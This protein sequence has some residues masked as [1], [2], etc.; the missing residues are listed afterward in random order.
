[1]KRFRLLIPVVILMMVGAV[2]YHGRQGSLPKE[3]FYSGVVEV[4]Q[5]HLAFERAGTIARYLADEG[6]PIQVGQKL[7]GL[8]VL[9]LKARQQGTRAAI[10]QARAQLEKLKAGSRVQEIESTRSRLRKAEA[11]L[12]RLRNGATAEEL[13]QVKSQM[14]A[15]RQAYAKTEH[16][17]RKEEVESARA[18]LD[19]AQSQM[20]TAESDLK[21]YRALHQEG[22]AP[23]Q[24]LEQQA[25]KFEIARSGYRTAQENYQLLSS[26]FRFEDRKAAQENFQ[27]AQARYQEMARGT[28]P[29][30]IAAAE[31]EVSYWAQQ[32]SL[33]KEGSRKEDI[34]VARAM[35]E[36]KAAELQ[37][38]EV[39]LK[40]SELFSPA[41][42][43]VTARPFEPGEMVAPG[44]PVLTVAETTSPWVAI[45]IPE[46]ELTS[47]HLGDTCQV[48]VDSQK[49]QKRTGRVVWIAEKAEFTPRYIQTE[50]QRVDLVFRVKV[51]VENSDGSLK[52]GMPADVQFSGPGKKQ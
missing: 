7:V 47:I 27:A 6:E 38:L 49:A 45:F 23:T 14:E 34:E 3:D 40:K 33:S 20:R 11:E 44:A 30:L 24:L 13:R 50:R 4:T 18:Q 36:Q 26:G 51:A 25:N 46:P 5:Y 15:Q 8:D 28:R 2:L 10:K 1:M 29:E 31:A 21:R 43:V 19:S 48:T 35:V 52:A 32:T 42:G 22:A 12:S 9:E 17:Y 16:G 39:Q 41:S 37:A